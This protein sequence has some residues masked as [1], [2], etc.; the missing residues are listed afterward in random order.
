[1]GFFSVAQCIRY[2][3]VPSWLG[4]YSGVWVHKALKGLTWLG[5]CSEEARRGCMVGCLH[6]RGRNPCSYSH[7]THLTFQDRGNS[8]EETL[9]ET[10]QSPPP[11]TLG[12]VLCRGFPLKRALGAPTHR[13]GVCWACSFLQQVSRGLETSSDRC[14]LDPTGSDW[15]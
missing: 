4:F 9:L 2:I 10:G 12:K 1:M 15:L 14:E 5:F 3:K 11:G 13:M 7:P 8:P 6:V